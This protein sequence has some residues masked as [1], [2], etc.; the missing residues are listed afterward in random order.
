MRI[1]FDHQSFVLQAYGGMSRYFARLAQGLLDLEQ[2]VGIFAPLH[3]NRHLSELSP[4]IV[5]G[6]YIKRYPPKTGRLFFSGN[7]FIARSQIAEYRPD[8]VHETYYSR[9][10]SAPR[11]C[12]ATITALDMIHEL[13]PRES[14]DSDRVIA[15]KRKA[16]GRADHVI[17]ISENTK[18]DLMRLYDFPEN[19]LSVVHLGFDR[20]L[21]QDHP[22]RDIAAHGN[23]PFV[24]Y[25]G[26]RG[27]HKNFKGLITAM[28][29]SPGLLADFNIIAFGGPEFSAEERA[30]IIASGFSDKQVQ[31][32]SGGDGMLGD[33]YRSARAFVYPSLYEGFGIP[34]LEA[35]AQNCPVVSSNASSMPE[36]IGNAG[37]YFDP[38]N[39]E[40]MRCAIERV[41]YSDE[42]IEWLR[43]AGAER[44]SAFS[45]AK[46]ARETLN[47]YRS[48][49]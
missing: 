16:I 41:V 38:A 9:M 35:M 28:A 40:D 26:Q 10:G 3:Q 2:Q 25:V 11:T 14:P 44:L 22:G 17:C 1:A 34:P 24:L 4:G 49:A 32:K 23:K 12:P 31:H 29:R 19:K 33:L 27:G 5:H 37:E 21:S 13:F 48:M 20:F 30:L 46:C 7:Q 15:I 36:V 42:R 8:V 6:R 45:W 43:R 18:S 47:V 39:L